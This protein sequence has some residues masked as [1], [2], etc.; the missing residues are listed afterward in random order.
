LAL[1]AL[2]VV[3]GDIGTS[4]LY[5]AKETFN[6]EHGIPLTPDNVLGGVSAIFWAL[7]IVVSLKYVALVLRATNRGEGGIMAL[8]A[9][10]LSSVRERPR[11]HAILLVVGVTGAA[12]F[13]GDAVLT[14]AISV[15]SAVEGLEVGTEIFKPWVVTI[16]VGVLIALF[17][18]QRFGTGVVGLL[19]GPS[20]CSV[21]RARR[22]G[23]GTSRASRRSS[24]RSIRGTREFVTGHGHA[25]FVVLGSVLLAIP[26]PRRYADMGHFGA[27][28]IA[29]RGSPSSPSTLNYFGQGALLIARPGDPNPF[30]LAFLSGRHRWWCSRRG[31]GHRIAGDDLRHLFADAAGHPAWL[32]AAD[33]RPPHFGHDQRPDL[34]SGGELDPA[35]RGVRRGRGLRQLVAARLRVRRRGHGDDAGDDDPDVLRPALRL[36]LSVVDVRRR[37]RHVPGCRRR[38]LRR[39]DAQGARWWLVSAGARRRRVRHHVHLE[40]RARRAA[41]E[42]GRVVAAARRLPA[43][44]SP[45]VRV[46]GTAVFLTATPRATP[47]ALLHNLKHYR[48]CTS[49]T[50]SRASSRRMRRRSPPTRASP[51]SGCPTAGA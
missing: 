3:Y 20:A 26:G 14:P 8:L 4:P 6:P 45:P 38:V 17:M 48:V 35:G 46:P 37:D 34:R 42:R 16:S 13:Y 31:N 44:R 1:L 21:H 2:S 43:S 51:A 23:C 40:P 18:I 32:P 30:Y 7:M 47:N 39:G 28:A 27:R 12:L 36:A 11:L 41:R 29:S 10:A 33:D 5:A 50:C 25:S 19:F 15:L 24:P 9:L 49:A 22:G